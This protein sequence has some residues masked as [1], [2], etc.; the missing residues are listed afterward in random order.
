LSS[1]GE[2]PHSVR[3]TDPQRLPLTNESELL[4]CMAS[5]YK[6][7]TFQSRYFVIENFEALLSLTAPDFT[8]HYRTLSIDA[9][10]E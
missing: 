3:S 1:P 4:R 8:P 5:R 10:D 2:L 6:I 7:D 9:I